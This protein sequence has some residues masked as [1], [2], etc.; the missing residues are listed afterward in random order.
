MQPATALSFPHGRYDAAALAAARDQG[1]GL[2]FTSDL[3]INPCPDGWLGSDMIGRIAVATADVAGPSG[4]L[5]PARLAA[6][7]FLRPCVPLAGAPA[8]RR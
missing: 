1:Y 8:E 7:M 4:R 5:S 3:A 6:W 2:I